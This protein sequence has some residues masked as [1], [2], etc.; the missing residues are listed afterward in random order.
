M[1]SNHFGSGYASYI[2]LLCYTDDFVTNTQNGVFRIEKRRGLHV[3]ISRLAPVI[4]I[5]SGS[6]MI[7]F[8]ESGAVNSRGE[9]MVDHPSELQI[10]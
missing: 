4:A 10:A 6:E 5:C 8:D 9:T 7:E 1:E 3:L 2:Q